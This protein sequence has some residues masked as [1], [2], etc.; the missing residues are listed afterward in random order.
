MPD[1]R[2]V[3]LEES[4]ETP[5]I[6]PSDGEWVIA[7]PSLPSDLRSLSIDM[8]PFDAHLQP[9]AFFIHYCCL[10]YEHVAEVHQ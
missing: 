9:V 7:K 4:N 2:V 3:L 1:R 6:G 5:T 10:G 8:R